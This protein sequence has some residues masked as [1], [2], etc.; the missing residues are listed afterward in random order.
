MSGVADGESS[1]ALSN[2]RSKAKS[3]AT[4][5]I[6]RGGPWLLAFDVDGTLAPIVTDAA[7]A[8]VPES[9]LLK[10]LALKEHPEVQLAF[11]TGRDAPALARMLP[12]HDV[13]RAVDH[14]LI[15]LGPGETETPALSVAETKALADYATFVDSLGIRTER[16]ERSVG[17]HVRGMEGGEAR[18]VSAEREAKSRGFHVRRGRALIEASFAHGDKGAAL[19]HI[20]EATGARTLLFAGDDL[21]DLSAIDIASETGIGVFVES[22][23]GPDVPA[24]AR[25][26]QG[27]A[28]V[29]SILAELQSQLGQ[30]DK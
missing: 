6:A 5:L 8:M 13:W 12:I 22:D 2:T 9:T 18:L 23:E 7:Q 26:V 20:A 15:L 14:G 3:I 24:G 17:A 28:G 30:L 11:L 25:C 4:D 29:E 21:T 1:I 27:P 10:L 16:K 19:R